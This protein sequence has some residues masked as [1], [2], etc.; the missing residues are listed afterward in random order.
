MSLFPQDDEDLVQ[1]LRRHRP[2]P[3]DAAPDLEAR[4]LRSLPP[5][6]S[7]R[8]SAR[9]ITIASSIAACFLGVI[10]ARQV[11]APTHDPTAIE[12]YLESSWSTVFDT[13]TADG[14]TNEYLTSNNN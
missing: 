6:R 8:D 11:Q 3:P 13:T 14:T 4:I 12:A 2:E 7:W 9:V 1:F 10:I 5:R